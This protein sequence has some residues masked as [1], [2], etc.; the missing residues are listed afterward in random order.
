METGQNGARA[1][2]RY[3]VIATPCA[4]GTLCDGTAR[5]ISDARF[6]LMQANIWSDWHTLGGSCYVGLARNKLVKQF[7][8]NPLATDFVFVDA[9]VSF[10]PEAL[11]QLLLHDVDV[12]AGAYRYK[13]AEERYPVLPFAEN[14]DAAALESPPA[15]DAE[16]G[17]IPAAMVPA[18]FLR[19]RR[20]VFERFR[21]HYGEIALQCIERNFDG[22][23]RDR[24]HNYFDTRQVGEQWF[25]EDVF[26]CRQWRAMGG[27]LWIDP[28]ITL[29]HTGPQRFTGNYYRF[30]RQ[31]RDDQ[32]AEDPHAG[33]KAALDAM[34]PAKR[35]ALAEDVRAI[36]QVDSRAL[37]TLADVIPFAQSGPSLPPPRVPR[38]EPEHAGPE[39]LL[40]CGASRVKSRVPPGGTPDWHD[41][42]TLDVN[43]AHNPHVVH[44]LEA[45]PYPFADD[46]FDEIHAY[47]VLEHT[48]RQGD[49]RF[50]FAQFAELWRILRPGGWLVGTVP[51]WDSE[52]AHG[53]P[54]HSRVLPPPVF[55]YLCQEQ[56]RQQI[57]RTMMADFRGVYTAD[58][59]IQSLQIDRENLRLAPDG[60][61]IE[62]VNPPNGRF[63]TFVLQAIK[64]S[65]YAAADLTLVEQH[66]D[67]QQE[68]YRHQK[69][70]W[71]A[72]EAQDIPRRVEP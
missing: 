56:Y 25:G 6:A 49:W 27:D 18:G 72:R 9:D 13:A 50:F 32:Q 5:S 58:F 67:V 20:G 46:T 7:L 10:P 15:W 12:V 40:G 66:R 33:L 48:G 70:L 22:T 41:L 52:F 4:G 60:R 26:F 3:V 35:R 1:P 16:R 42:V 28:R 45:L 21:R 24:F 36:G 30:L 59:R 61:T 43:P 65:S 69:A 38:C 51:A 68:E 19:I 62:R 29:T 57:G 31:G 63:T 23:E 11:V 8:D 39:L 44:D 37:P 54:S 2:L 14:E 64:P 55:A 47:E 71:H 53:D 17:L 34:P